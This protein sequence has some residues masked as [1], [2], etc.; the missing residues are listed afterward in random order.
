MKTKIFL[1]A[2]LILII[3]LLGCQPS[4]VSRV[5]WQEHCFAVELAQTPS[6][7][8]QGLMNRE[9][10][11]QNEGMLFIFDRAAIHSFWMKNTLTPLDIIWLNEAQEV[12]GLFKNAAPCQE[13]L[14][15]AYAPEA[16]A[17]YVL[18]INA[19]LVDQL[20]IKKGDRFEFKLVQ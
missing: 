9:Q 8:A 13:D 16:E 20:G 5:C 6:E 17:K 14:C 10:L 7:R 12:V 3:F 11:D 19:G 15:P 2:I 4:P 18:E 1:P